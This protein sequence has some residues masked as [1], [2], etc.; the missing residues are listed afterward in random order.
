V[1][2]P[3]W[4]PKYDGPSAG[5][6]LAVAMI[7]AYSGKSIPKNVTMTGEI[8]FHGNVMPVGGIKEK[9][10]ATYEKGVDKVYIPKENQ[11]DY[12]D[13]LIKD[14]R[15][16]M[17]SATEKP[18]LKLPIIVAVKT[19]DEVVEDLG[20]GVDVLENPSEEAKE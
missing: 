7:S 3:G 1:D 17:I 9:I 18:S 5:V 15:Q 11:W 8:S 4:F 2:V 14:T 10:E 12:L 6:N 16:E 20:I 13:M 19:I